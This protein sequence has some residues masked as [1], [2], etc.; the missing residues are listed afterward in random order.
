MEK[1]AHQITEN[2]LAVGLSANLG[3]VERI[4]V[5]EHEKPHVLEIRDGAVMGKD[6]ASVMKRMRVFEAGRP[7]GRAAHVGD[8]GSGIDARRDLAEVFAVI[9]GPGAFLDLR[10]PVR[11][12]GDPPAMTVHHSGEIGPG[13]LHKGVLGLDE[14]AFDPRGFAG[15]HG[16]EPAHHR[17]SLV[18]VTA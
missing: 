13:L 7:D 12:V 14:S 10:H 17:A 16:V 18:E 2:M 6:P 8:D 4:D 9:G 1:Q 15:M 3:A 5:V 11:I